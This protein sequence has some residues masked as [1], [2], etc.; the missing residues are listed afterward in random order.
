[1]IIFITAQNLPGEF[2]SP[3]PIRFFVENS[4]RWF[5]EEWFVTFL[6]TFLATIVGG[7]ILVL[8]E[9]IRGWID[10]KKIIKAIY[11]E[12]LQNIQLQLEDTQPM[13]REL[14]NEVNNINNNAKLPGSNLRLRHFNTQFRNFFDSFFKEIVLIEFKTLNRV[15]WFYKNLERQ[16]AIFREITLIFDE[17]NKSSNQNSLR[18]ARTLIQVLHE[19]I[20]RISDAGLEALAFITSRYNT[21][22]EMYKA[23]YTDD[24]VKKTE[25]YLNQI[26]SGRSFKLSDFVSATNIFI[27]NANFLLLRNKSVE[28]GLPPGIF[29]K[30]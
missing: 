4:Y 11:N 26:I 1:M 6:A 23:S 2:I 15:L 21:F 22:S 29:I 8:S 5:Q 18:D 10:R 12:I 14:L 30:K 27:L 20:Y 25:V 17:V 16:Q 7:V 9:F 28:A 24:D 3:V 19:S 13:A